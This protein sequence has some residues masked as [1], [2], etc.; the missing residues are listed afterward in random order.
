VAIRDKA[1]LA[2]AGIAVLV[3]VWVRFKGFGAWPLAVD[4]YYIFR[5]VGFIVESGLPE[6]PCGGFYT[7][8]L[9]YQYALAPLIIAGMPPESALR[10][11][12][13]LCSLLV[14]PAVYLLTR[15]LVPADARKAAACAAVAVL[16]LSAWEIEMARFGRMYAPFQAVFVWYLYH[17]WQLINRQELW[18]WRWLIGL[19]ILGPFV[20]EGGV[21]LALLNFLPMLLGKRYWRMPHLAISA[22]VL[23]VV[24]VVVRG[25]FRWL[26]PIPAFPDEYLE[27]RA[28]GGESR[29]ARLFGDVLLAAEQP[30]ALR[31]AAVGLAVLALVAAGSVLRQSR[32][33]SPLAYLAVIATVAALAL[34]QFVL[35]AAL[36]VG[37]WLLGWVDRH[38]LGEAGWR[39]LLWVGGLTTAGW[40]A[41][42][43]AQNPDALFTL[44]AIRALRPLYAFPDFKMAIVQPWFYTIPLWSALLTAGLVGSL[45]CAGRA[46]ANAS[47][48]IRWLLL[49]ILIC[50]TFVAL[51]PTPYRETRYSFFLYPALIVASVVGLSGLRT[52]IRT[53]LRWPAATVPVAVLLA[54]LAMEDFQPRHLLAIDSYRANF[55]VGYPERLV[56]HYYERNDHKAP[57]DFLRE[58]ARAGD[59]IIITEVALQAYLPWLDYVYLWMGDERFGNQSC[60][61]GTVERWSNVPLLF[62]EAAVKRALASRVSGSTWIVVTKKARRWHAWEQSLVDHL[63]TAPVFTP[64][65]GSFEIYRVR[66]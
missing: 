58:H 46:E 23:P 65:D 7:R 47:Q 13:I 39:R 63:A 51:A 14:L 54:F 52:T 33:G 11:I 60:R 6:Y 21:V 9:V 48:G 5:S 29:L 45:A 1:W 20:W 55:R 2:L 62:D 57:G 37:S 34:N 66:H 27:M 50:A 4:E 32:P 61:R 26:S 16:A 12:T 41:L 44:D 43:W 28:G 40:I 22:L 59:S 3:G 19:S 36:L 64:P 24:Y 15:A 17:A 8:G 10:L 35:A 56:A 25:P 53:A 18:R 30:V 38:T 49:A 31:L 42:L